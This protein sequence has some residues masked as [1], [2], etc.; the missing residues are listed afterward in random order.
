MPLPAHI[1]RTARFSSFSFDLNTG[2]LTRNGMRLRLETQPARILELLILANGDLVRRSELIATLWPG[3]IEGNF[4]RRLDKAVAKLRASLNDDPIQP[5]YVETLKGKGYRFIA[6]VV[7]E[8]VT[9]TQS[10]ILRKGDVSTRNAVS[11]L[12]EPPKEYLEPHP[13]TSIRSGHSIRRLWVGVAA[14]F[15]LLAAVSVSWFES[16]PLPS[17]HHRLVIL[18]AGFRDSSES[19][20]DEWVSHSASEWLTSALTSGGDLQLVRIEGNSD[21]RGAIRHADCGKLPKHTVTIA[22]EAFNADVVIYGTSSSIDD[23]SGSQWRLSVCLVDVRSDRLPELIT[24]VGTENDIAQ[25]ALQAGRLLRA[26]LGLKPLSEESVGYLRATL[27]SNPAAARLYSEGSLALEDFQPQEASALLQQAAQLDPQ[28]APTHAALSTAWASLGYEQKSR[29]EA[30]LAKDLAKT[31]SPTQRLE[32]EA[33]ADE[34]ANDWTAAAAVYSSLLQRYPD[35]TEYALKL[36]HAQSHAAKPELALETLRGLRSGNPAAVNDPRVDLVEADADSALSDFHK[37]LAAATRAESL[38]RNPGAGLL[39][40]DAQMAQGNADDALGNWTE[41]LRLWRVAAQTYELIG[42][43]SGV[44]AA[45][46]REATLAWKK[47]DSESA[48][49]LFDESI[50][51]SKGTGDDAQ[52]AY[53]LSRLG[54]VLMAVD[55]APGGEMPE[56]VQMYRQAASLY[57]RM[58]NVAEEGYVFSL[59][60]DEA[61]QRTQFETG[62]AFYMK[63]IALSKEAHDNSRVAG[64]LLDLGIVE[65]AEGHNPEA[66]QFF[67]E[68]AAE[69]DKLGQKDRAAIS[70]I[71]LGDALYRAGDVEDAERTLQ[72][73]LQVMRSF[74]RMNQVRE[75][76]GDLERVEVWINPQKAERVARENLDLNHRMVDARE[77]CAASIALV[78]ESLLSEGRTADAKEAIQ[79]AFSPQN[80][81]STESLPDMLIK[82]GNIRMAGKDFAGADAD[83]R[84]ALK[85]SAARGDRYFQLQARLGLAEVECLRDVPSSKLELDLLKRDADASGMGIFD[86]KIQFFL[87]TLLPAP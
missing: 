10:N 22:R 39:I 52:L 77:C 9:G 70:R 15:T 48:T 20:G 32:Y 82:R 42:D 41:A 3:E 83:L 67:K 86:R 31:L 8:A 84:R 4:A 51:L 14:V 74:G 18:F 27:P 69:F 60:G 43:R 29:Q 34:A 65:F 79:R 25:L 38:A 87:R 73:S 12:H 53:S 35:S 46:N 57:R 72:D 55:R 21:L 30:L 50:A 64:R 66:I 75:A 81:I 68:S 36:A 78:A 62:R 76:V 26:K 23:V 28:H 61:M 1:G 13:T 37:Q 59:L 58:S 17:R 16:R 24:V 80:E 6:D 56:A 2:D 63:A 71:R 44:A 54:I 47:G 11:A 19:S 85:I 33:L 40:A 49:K 5:R 7:L 45:L